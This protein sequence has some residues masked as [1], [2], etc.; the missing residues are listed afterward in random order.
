LWQ[1]SRDVYSAAV[2]PDPEDIDWN[3]HLDLDRNHILLGLN[4]AGPLDALPGNTQ[5]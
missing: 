4:Q 1:V 5:N 2:E 3:N